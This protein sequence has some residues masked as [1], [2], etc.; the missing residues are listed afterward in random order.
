MDDDQSFGGRTAVT[1]LTGELTGD[2]GEHG[3]PAHPDLR[4]PFE[5]IETVV[6]RCAAW[7]TETLAEHPTVAQARVMS[8]HGDT[9][10]VMVNEWAANGRRPY[11]YS[12]EANAD[13]ILWNIPEA[14]TGWFG[15]APDASTVR[16]E[17]RRPSQASV[18]TAQPGDATR[19]GKRAGAPRRPRGPLAAPVDEDRRPVAA[20]N[21]MLGVV[22]GAQ[23]R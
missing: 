16:S 23:R 18:E 4:G 7:R 22:T 2:A 8:R 20:V 17:P 10:G 12:Y 3:H 13:V 5:M 21:P 9:I 6:S 1:R 14:A 15:F 19:R 11:R